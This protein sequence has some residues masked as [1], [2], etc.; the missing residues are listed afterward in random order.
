MSSRHGGRPRS[1][2]KSGICAFPSDRWYRGSLIPMFVSAGTDADQEPE[3]SFL[4]GCA[5]PH[6]VESLY[7]LTQI[8]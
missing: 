7:P 1:T 3:M 4:S 5:L 8:A 2:V 6:C